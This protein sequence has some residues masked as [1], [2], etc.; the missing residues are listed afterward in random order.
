MRPDDFRDPGLAY[1]PSQLIRPGG[2]PDWAAS[3]DEL[4]RL[5][6]SG[7]GGVMTA[8]NRENYLGDEAHWETLRAQLA[9]L[10]RLGM[11]AWIRDDSGRPS[12]KAAGKVVAR[13]PE[14][15][16]RGLLYVALPAEGQTSLPG[17]IG[18]HVGP[19]TAAPGQTSPPGD[20]KRAPMPP[21][22]F[23]ISGPTQERQ[24]QGVRLPLPAGRPIYVGALPWEGDHVSLAGA[25]RLESAVVDGVVAVSLP[26]GRWLIAALI[27]RPMLDGTF[28]HDPGAGDW[29]YLNL[30]DRRAVE[31]FVAINHE[32]YWERVGDYFG[33]VVEGF[34]ADEP[35]LITTAFPVKTEFPP[36]PVIP[37]L[38]ELPT[39]FAVRYGYD[40]VAHLPALFNDVGPITARVRCDF[41]RLVGDL[42]GQSFTRTIGDWCHAKGV[43]LK[44]QPLGEESLV[45]H[46]ALEGSIFPFLAPADV[47]CPDLLSATFETFKSRDQCLPA[48]KVV[49]SVAHVAERE[50]VIADF[51]DW[52]QLRCGV[53]TS[54]GEMRGTIGYLFALGVDELHTLYAWRKRDPAELRHLND[55]AARLSLALRG[56]AHVADLAVLYP[57]TTIWAHYVPSTDFLMLPPIGSLERPKIWSESY[58]AEATNWELPFRELVW[59]LLEHQR[60]FDLVDD[61]ALAPSPQP[62]PRGRGGGG[63]LTPALPQ[64]ERAA[65][66][67]IANE[68]YRALVLPRM[69]VIDRRTLDRAEAYARDGGVVVGFAPLPTKSAQQ[70]EDRDLRNA[71]LALF[72]E[73]IPFGGQYAARAVGQGRA[74]VVADIA[75]LLRALSELVPPDIHLEPSSSAVLGLHRRREGHDVY[76]LTNCGPEPADLTVTLRARGQPEVWDPLDGTV[77]VGEYEDTP[78][79]TRLRLL[80]AGYA[81]KLVVL[82]TRDMPSPLAAVPERG[83]RGEGY[84]QGEVSPRRY[85]P[86]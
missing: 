34:H 53:A 38:A 68:R 74:V 10:R 25:V 20:P 75:G 40:L 8:L 77:A 1:R 84:S 44:A 46:T 57:M 12:G 30:L 5:K 54:V 39:L 65:E 11:R 18:A 21:G 82:G 29:P 3:V 13:Y 35:M 27:E 50:E 81:G 70:G 26:A 6:A 22:P 28:A 31:T 58:A 86:L 47:L 4:A 80:L 56:G 55:Y 78:D 14:G 71:A 59:S 66:L 49:S 41:Y 63:A 64:R 51:T 32:A 76:L 42:C 2:N 61:D 33:D 7:F 62:S 15:E 9:E 69:D 85:L 36:Y 23:S 52:Y 37:W 83:P 73:R 16:A 72:G 79:G 19:G 48:P 17:P 60:D 67:V 45:V 24:V 43:R